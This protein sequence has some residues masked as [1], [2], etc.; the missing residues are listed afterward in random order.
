VLDASYLDEVL[1]VTQDLVFI[2]GQ[3]MILVALEEV[4][5]VH[6]LEIGR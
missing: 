1:K 5:W 2:D 4:F 6:Y 3:V